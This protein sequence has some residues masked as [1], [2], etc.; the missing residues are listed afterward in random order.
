MENRSAFNA[1]DMASPGGYVVPDGL[2]DLQQVHDATKDSTYLATVEA[3]LRN[4]AS[5]Y[6]LII[7]GEVS[8]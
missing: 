4:L 3:K 5:Q 6:G 1:I 2:Y 8:L 7:P